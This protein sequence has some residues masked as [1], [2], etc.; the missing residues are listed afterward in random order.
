MPS[1]KDIQSENVEITI[2]TGLSGAGKSQAIKCFEDMGY[3]CVDNL[4]PDLIFKFADL[5]SITDSNI[6][7]VA[8]VIDVRG[9]EFFSSLFDAIDYMKEKEIDYQ[10][11]FLE[12][13][14]ETL[15]KRFKETRRRH[16]LAEEGRVSE[17]IERERRLL[18]S[19]R[20]NADLIIDTSN[21]EVHELKDKIKDAFLGEKRKR[22]ILVT[23]VSFG[24]KY[25]LPMDAD[26]AIDVRFLPNPHYIKELKL[27]TGN[28]EKVRNFVLKRSE[29]RLFLR[30]IQNLLN[31]L[32]PLYIKEGKTH[33]NI[34]IGC[35]GGTHRSVVLT[36]ETAKF[37]NKK[38]YSVNVYHR[39]IGKDF[40]AIDEKK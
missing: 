3:F 23:V 4:P 29:T 37:L 16:P 13:S 36:E 22:L 28:D 39:D 6:K 5:I 20:G 25:G 31:F 30:K 24:Y 19:L 14:D 26:L 1:K 12:A 2:I 35:T 18:E 11:L 7:K 10:I 9:G 33:L 38:G 17:G 32:L 34:A 15:I 8:L 21:L 40:Q 27:L